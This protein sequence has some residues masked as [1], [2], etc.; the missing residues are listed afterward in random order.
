MDWWCCS[1]R[2]APGLRWPVRSSAGL[3]PSLLV[4]CGK[5]GD[6]TRRSLALVCSHQ[7]PRCKCGV[8][9]RYSSPNAYPFESHHPHSGIHHFHH[10]HPPALAPYHTTTIPLIPIPHTHTAPFGHSRPA[11]VWRVSIRPAI[12]VI[13]R[14]SCGFT[15]CT[16]LPGRSLNGQLNR[17]QDR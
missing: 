13:S 4:N 16:D 11:P 17:D 2:V 8:L 9:H 5:G 6:P 12:V 15:W 10:F 3:L 1:S 7:R 14:S